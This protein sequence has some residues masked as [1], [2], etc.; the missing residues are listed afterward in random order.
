[1]ILKADK[2]GVVLIMNSEDYVV[3]I[4][5][6]LTLSGSYEKLDSNLMARIT[7]ELIKVIKGSN[8]DDITKKHFLPSCEITPRIYGLLKIHK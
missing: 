2:G 5:E 1:V 3:K 8:L 4:I 7:R 6:H